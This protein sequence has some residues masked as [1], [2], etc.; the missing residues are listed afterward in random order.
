MGTHCQIGYFDQTTGKVFAS[1]CHYD[2]YIDGVGVTLVNHYNTHTDAIAVATSGYFSSLKTNLSDSLAASVHKDVPV[3]K[4]TSV[5]DYLKDGHNDCGADYL[6]L[7]DGSAWFVAPRDEA[8][9]TD[10]E[11]MLEKV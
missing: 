1:Y 3:T 10:V 4:Y 8:L 6:Y 9:F 11:T 7:W 5:V 2:G